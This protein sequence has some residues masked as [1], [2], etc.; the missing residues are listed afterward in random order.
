MGMKNKKPATKPGK[1]AF[2]ALLHKIDLEEY[3]EF[4]RHYAAKNQ[5]F[6]AELEVY[7]ADK[8]DRI[9]V[10]EKYEDLVRKLIRRYSDQ[11]YVD[12][13]A[14]TELS[15]EVDR[16]LSTGYDLAAK[17]NPRD[18][19]LM[20]KPVLRQM[21]EALTKSDDS[22]GD[23]GG[24][25]DNII[26]LIATVTQAVEAAPELK[27]QVF[28]FLQ[29]ELTEKIYFEYG[30]FGYDLFRVYQGLAVQLGK[31]NE[32]VRFV[33]AQVPR[34]GTP[35]ENYRGEFYRK[36]NIAFFQAIGKPEEAHKL[37]LQSLDIVEVRQGEVEKAIARKDLA[38]AKELITEGIH[39]AEEKGRRGTV[40]QWRKELLRIALLENDLD[41]VRLYTKHFAVNSRFDAE[42]YKQWKKTYPPD[43]WKETIA[44]YLEAKTEEI[45]EAHEKKKGTPWH[46]PNPP[47]LS[48]LAPVYIEEKYWDRL[49][50]LVKK[51]NSLEIALQYHEYLFKKYP[52]DL[53]EIYLP[54][55]RRWGDQ[56]SSRQEYAKL[57]GTMKKVMED[58]PVSK[59][60]IRAIARELKAKYARK[61]AFIDE[62][63]AVLRVD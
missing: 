60:Q 57:A 25:I 37:I 24:T 42:Y 18:A 62:L 32:Y 12:Y 44:Q 61:P 13:R 46:K 63:N 14:A 35:H 6:Q 3:R 22:S 1:T 33:D 53:L 10:S 5:G 23:I 30:D 55:F 39:L 47:L 38:V 49:L 45:T 15:N 17:G 48:A 50:A 59:E 41:A 40:D 36:Q 58:I 31:T 8:D 54:A 29:N 4:L 27:E 52:S 9:D 56:V 16:L 51:E 26:Q 2:E 43:Q 34:I 21:M 19:F 28:A 7:F 11:G 20:A